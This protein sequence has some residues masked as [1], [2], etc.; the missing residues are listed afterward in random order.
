[1]E[2]QVVVFVHIHIP[3]SMMALSFLVD[4]YNSNAILVIKIY[5][6]SRTCNVESG[7]SFAL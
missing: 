7:K 1:M 4:T 3:T 2:S 5:N 6:N